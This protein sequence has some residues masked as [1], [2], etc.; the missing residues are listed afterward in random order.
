MYK[1]INHSGNAPGLFPRGDIQDGQ[2]KTIEISKLIICYA[3]N[4]HCERAY[5][6][7]RVSKAERLKVVV[8]A[9]LYLYAASSPARPRRVQRP[10][11]VLGAQT[12][13][14][15]P[16]RETTTRHVRTKPFFFSIYIHNL[17]YI[18]II[19]YIVFYYYLYTIIIICI[20]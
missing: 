16:E 17:I 9:R 18:T 7:A 6:P 5:A 14:W 8:R 1:C 10:T 12:I 3:T 2:K 11:R 13:N 20:L 15:Q 19:L 4:V